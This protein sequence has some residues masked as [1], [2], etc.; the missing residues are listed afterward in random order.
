MNKKGFTLVE[1]LA[2]VI[3]L[4]L[5]ALITSTSVTKMVKD[6][7]DELSETQIELIKTSAKT[8]GAD[9]L[10]KLP[11]PGKCSYLTLGD[12]KEYGLIDSKVINASTNKEISDNLIIKLTTTTNSYGNPITN[13]EVNSN[14]ISGCSHNLYKKY[15]NG[16]E[17]YFDVKNGKACT[18]RE[19]ENSWDATTQDYLNSK[20]G[21]NGIKEETDTTNANSCLKFYAFNDNQET[22]IVNLLLDHNIGS[23]SWSSNGSDE[24]GPV[25]LLSKLKLET[26]SWKGTEIPN[27][28]RYISYKDQE[29]KARLITAQEVADLVKIENFNENSTGNGYYNFSSN[30][31]YEWLG[32]NYWTASVY[33]NGSGGA[34]LVGT[35]L[36]GGNTITS[37]SGVRPVI[38]VSKSKF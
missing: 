18:K 28:Y 16:E 33:N 36:I 21:Y 20:T 31:G 25:D 30:V 12:L 23:S 38:E 26:D 14:D 37:Q 22:K 13:Y 4:A 15:E 8:W 17:V 7:K 32:N 19:Y 29:Y 34:W 5:L 27:N 35:N 6:S 3:I 11:S 1:L 24:D 2:V 10:D 9:N